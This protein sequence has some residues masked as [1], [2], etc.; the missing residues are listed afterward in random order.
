MIV[1]ADFL[2]EPQIASLHLD[3]Q[4]HLD[5]IQK[6]LTVLGLCKPTTKLLSRP[7][8][9]KKANSDS[10]NTDNSIMVHLPLYYFTVV[11]KILISL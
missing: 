11:Y 8:Y 6:A 3:T 2:Y 5:V 1:S 9:L 7:P 10:C 4:T